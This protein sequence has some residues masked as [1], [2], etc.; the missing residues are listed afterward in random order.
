M[1]CKE[2]VVL[3]FQTLKSYNRIDTIHTLLNMCL[4]F[5]LRFLGTCLEEFVRLEG[6][7]LRGIDL[8]VNNAADL[9]SELMACQLTEPTNLYVRRKMALYLSLL[10]ENHCIQEIF[11]LLTAWGNH[12]FLKSAEGDPLEELLLV[13]IMA[14][15]HPKFESYQRDICGIIFNKMKSAAGNEDDGT[16]H[17]RTMLD[18]PEM[19][20]SHSKTAVTNTVSNQPMA[21]GGGVIGATGVTNVTAAVAG[22]AVTKKT[23]PPSNLPYSIAPTLAE[24]TPSVNVMSQLGSFEPSTGSQ[25]IIKLP[26]AE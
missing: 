11:N 9:T 15:L 23:F 16:S 20:V 6:S 10:R 7:E 24:Q 3:W 22:P 13:Y 14:A 2:D 12:E 5:E 4:P 17:Q 25:V 26:F 21:G 8:R 1:V 19:L 18:V